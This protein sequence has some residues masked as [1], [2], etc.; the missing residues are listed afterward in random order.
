MKKQNEIYEAKLCA[1]AVDAFSAHVRDFLTALKLPRREVLRYGMT[2]EEILFKS[3]NAGNDG[4]DI[5]LSMGKKFMS[6]FITLELGGEVYNVYSEQESEQGVLGGSI[7]KSLGLSPEYKFTGSVNRYAFRIRR[8]STSPFVSLAIAAVLAAIIGSLGYLLPDAARMTLLDKL[9]IPL[10]DTFLDLL[11]CIA[12]PMIF[13]AVAWGIYGI[14]DAAALKNIGKKLC[15]SYIGTSCIAA[16]LLCLLAI[17]L[18][19]LHFTAASGTGSGLSDAFAMILGIVPKDIF[20]PFVNGNTLQIIFIAVVI[21]IAMLFLGQKTDFVAKVVEQINYIVQFLIEAISKLVPV[22]IFIVLLK[23]MWSDMLGSLSGIGK[24]AGVFFGSVL[25]CAV[26]VVGITA[27]KNRVSPLLLAKKGLNTLLIALSTASSAAAFGS[28]M[29]TA[30]REYGIDEKLCSFGIPLGVVTYKPNAALNYVMQCL[31]FAEMYSLDISV[32]WIVIL[33]ITG[34]ILAVATPPI[35]GGGMA[36][37][38]V[39]FAQLGI[40][41]EALAIALACETVFDFIITGFDQFG[42][43]LV[44]LNQAGRLGFAEREKLLRR[45]A[46]NSDSSVR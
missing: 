16:T 5:K 17:P 42:I 20:S 24:L 46:D 35:P 12:G 23:L 41:T 9:L 32:S 39:L 6:F 26:G 30:K 43:S 33:L 10:N 34:I 25:L 15:G 29:N 37:Y 27:L 44:L 8:R 22:F 14:G 19:D 11:G 4:V 7:L 2:V 45:N 21:G 18:F 28:N 1:D 40:P 38:A 13:L 36:T 3:M 31:F